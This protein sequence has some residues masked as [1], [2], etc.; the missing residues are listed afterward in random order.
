LRKYPV[1]YA[2]SIGLKSTVEVGISAPEYLWQIFY[3]VC[4][5]YI[6]WKVTGSIP[7]EII[8]FFN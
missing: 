4:M 5:F 2:F 3:A 7:D 1:E 6:P 8:G